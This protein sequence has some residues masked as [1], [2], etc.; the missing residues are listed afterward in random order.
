MI[1]TT[2][3]NRM[4]HMLHEIWSK[5]PLLI[6]AGLIVTMLTAFLILLIIFAAGRKSPDST[7][8]EP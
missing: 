6:G 7:R 2:V 5:P 4:L 3:I 1:V 8:R